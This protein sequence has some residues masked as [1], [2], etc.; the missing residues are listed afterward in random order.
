MGHDYHR[1]GGL[2]E[3]QFVDKYWDPQAQGGEGGWRYPEHQGFDG[4]RTGYVPQV[5]ERFDRFGPASGRYLSPQD[6]PFAERALPPDSVDITRAD[7]G[8]HAYEVAKPWD[9]TAG[10]MEIGIVAEAFEQPGGGI[11]VLTEHRLDW[12]L[13]HGYL[14]AVGTGQ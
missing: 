4:T 2:T 9:D 11:Q 7:L 3:Q 12:L 6:T 5:G 13:E 14:R 1:F 8:Y 10:K